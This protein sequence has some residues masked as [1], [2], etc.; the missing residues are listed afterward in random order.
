MVEH[1]GVQMA[2]GFLHE[3]QGWVV[4]MASGA[5]MVLEMIALARIGSGHKTL[6]GAVWAGASGAYAGDS[7]SH[8]AA[9]S[10]SVYML[11][12]RH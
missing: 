6:A 7:R 1:W 5:I 2:E 3:F 10:V 4:F 9:D 12:P 8:G 11:A